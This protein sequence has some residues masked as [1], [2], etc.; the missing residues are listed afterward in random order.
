MAPRK[1]D[2]TTWGERIVIIVLYGIIILVVALAF[3]AQWLALLLHYR[4]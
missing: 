1:D 4:H 3:G 2:D